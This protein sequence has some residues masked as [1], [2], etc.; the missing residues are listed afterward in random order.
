MFKQVDL[1]VFTVQPSAEPTVA[2]SFATSPS[3]SSSPTAWV[4]ATVVV[5]APTLSTPTVAASS[6]SASSG[7]EQ[8]SAAQANILLD[9]PVVQGV[10][11]FTATTYITLN[12]MA[13]MA[14]F[15]VN[16]RLRR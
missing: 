12:L 6:A 9:Y 10:V 5:N 2:T 3:A 13:D 16:P 4:Q 7:V 1:G 11:L 14:Y 15:W 8:P